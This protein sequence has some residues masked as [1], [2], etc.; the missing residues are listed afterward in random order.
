MAGVGT[1][2]TPA[3]LMPLL[4]EIAK[5]EDI[6]ENL[7][8]LLCIA[9]S[10]GG[11]LSPIAPTGVIGINLGRPVGLPSY[12]PI[13]MMSLVIY[14]IHGIL[15]FLAL[16]G[17]KL[18]KKPSTS[19]PPFVLNQGQL[20]TLIVMAVVIGC[21]LILKY[22]LGLSAFLGAA[23]LLSLGTIDTE[24]AVKNVS[25]ST[26]LLICGV[27]VLVNVVKVSGGIDL[28]AN[29]LAKI[30]T[31]HAA[32]AV[33]HL[34]GGLMSSVSSASGVVMPSLIPTIPGIIEKLGSDVTVTH[35]VAGVIIG[36]HVVPYSP[37][38]TMGAIGMAAATERSNKDKL[39]VQL[40]ASAFSMLV[41]TTML[42]WFG[43][44]N[45]FS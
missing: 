14:S 28:T 30:M 36:A 25:W 7:T 16:G 38:S 32:P 15:Y 3:V 43:F 41:F 11:G 29:Y 37:L 24:K 4:L 10:I 12:T 22:D 35:L 5:E 20:Y 17:W 23:V 26:L 21:V 42:I 33:M 31:P 18:K 45:L 2:V 27:S 6:P 44:F 40:M 8:I 9:G 13:F 34:L 1:I 39:F 19:R